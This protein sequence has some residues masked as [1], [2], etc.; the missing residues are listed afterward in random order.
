VEALAWGK[1]MK[2]FTFSLATAAAAA[3]VQ[4]HALTAEADWAEITGDPAAPHMRAAARHATAS[5]EALQRGLE[6]SSHAERRLQA[7]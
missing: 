3:N 5:F 6:I 2:R 1:Y 4:A 7:A